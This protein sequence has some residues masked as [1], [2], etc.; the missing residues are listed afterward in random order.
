M[1]QTRDVFPSLN[2]EENLNV[3]ARPGR[4]TLEGVYDLFPRLRERRGNGGNQLSGG[5]QQMLSIGRAL[6]GNPKLLLLD[7][8]MEGLAPIVVEMLLKAFDRLVREHALAIILVEQ[9]ARLALRMTENVIVMNRGRVV[10]QGTSAALLKDE[11]A[12]TRLLSAA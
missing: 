1:P 7:E 12:M 8:P 11:A 9:H 5:E 6:M 3:A 4:W 10:H 2:V